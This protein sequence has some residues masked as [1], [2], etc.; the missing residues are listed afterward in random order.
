M[1]NGHDLRAMMGTGHSSGGLLLLS[2]L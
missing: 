2:G 1:V